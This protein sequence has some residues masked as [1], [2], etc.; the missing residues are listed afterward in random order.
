MLFR[1]A[2]VLLLNLLAFPFIFAV[3]HNHLHETKKS[4]IQFISYYAIVNLLAIVGIVVF[5]ISLFQAVTDWSQIFRGKLQNWYIYCGLFLFI[6][7]PIILW[8]VYTQIQTLVKPDNRNYIFIGVLFLLIPLIIWLPQGFSSYPH[9]EI[10]TIKTYF[11]GG[12]YQPL[13][14][15]M[16]TRLSI[17]VPHTLIHFFESDSYFLYNL[18]HLL[19]TSL[20][21]LLVFA[22]LKKFNI[23][24]ALT[25]PI[26]LLFIVYPTFTEALSLRNFTVLTSVVLF[27]SAVYSFL[28]YVDNENRLYLITFFVSMYFSVTYNEYTFLLILAFP[29]LL[30]AKIGKINVRWVQ[31]TVVWYILPFAYAVYYYL[32]SQV[33]PAYGTQH[34]TPSGTLIETLSVNFSNTFSLLFWSNWV[35]TITQ[36]ASSPAVVFVSII[37][38]VIVSVAI[39]RLMPS[40]VQTDKANKYLALIGLGFA[41]VGLTA[42]MFSIFNR[43]QIQWRIYSM[44]SLG[45]SIVILSILYIFLCNILKQRY[46]YLL[47]VGVIFAIAFLNSF[48]QYN[49]YQSFTQSNPANRLTDNIEITNTD[50]AWIWLTEATSEDYQDN[51]FYMNR[52]YFVREQ[53]L[54]LTLNQNVPEFIHVCHIPEQNCDFG[55]DEVY[56]YLRDDNSFNQ[57][58]YPYS[59]VVFFWIN[60]DLSIEV[61]TNLDNLPVRLP[62]LTNAPQYQ[63]LNHIQIE[64]N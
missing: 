56:F 29:V 13:T 27:L 24:D 12:E 8:F 49:Y 6:Y 35:D 7:I 18:T 32:I 43:D 53:V 28:T 39:Y 61:L 55:T 60:P 37:V 5:D 26:A 11:S 31:L 17:L 51:Y 46:I 59:E 15:E 1:I 19:L 38:A 34:I 22:I 33:T 42:I 48:Q 63:P 23:T 2:C 14:R 36:K 50:V 57:S 20:K 25:L 40:H 52:T 4:A 44:G 10:W 41:V 21:G 62:E 30:L 54:E 47:A 64:S 45:A 16:A 58:V 9:W 3:I